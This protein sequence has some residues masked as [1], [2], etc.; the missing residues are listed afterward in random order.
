MARSRRR[1]AREDP[2]SRRASPANTNR[3]AAVHNGAEPWARQRIDAGADLVLVVR[4]DD[5]AARDEE[6]G[7]D[8]VVDGEVEGHRSLE[9]LALV[10][11]Q[12]PFEDGVVEDRPEVAGDRA[13]CRAGGLVVDEALDEIGGPGGEDEGGRGEDRAERDRE[14]RERGELLPHGIRTVYEGR[15]GSDGP[16]SPRQGS[17]YYSGGG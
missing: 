9:G 6:L 8:D 16:P 14:P 7:R 13:L 15:E 5:H 2:P 1:R 4:E 3:P 10:L 12:L 17:R 11:R